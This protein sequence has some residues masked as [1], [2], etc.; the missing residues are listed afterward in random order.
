MAVPLMIED[1][2]IGALAVAHP[3]GHHFGDA[4]MDILKSFGDQ[5][6][7]ALEGGRVHGKSE[8]Q[9]RALA[10][11]VDA[12]QRL[13]HG[14]DLRVVLDSLAEA[15]ALL[16]GGEAGVRMVEGDE[17]VRISAT[18]GAARA[19]STERLRIGES[20][21]GRVAATGQP[22]FSEDTARDDRVIPEHRALDTDERARSLVCVPIRHGGRVLGTLNLYGALGQRFDD[23]IVRVV[24]SFADQAAIAIE[25]A[26]LF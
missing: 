15:A 1:R 24:A 19:M 16:V 6:A 25:N 23:E 22:M 8:R 4:E 9:R 5:A 17:L 7:I 10:T 3:T 14:L 12:T 13:A 21:S 26:R 11:L 18:A 2:V 20:I